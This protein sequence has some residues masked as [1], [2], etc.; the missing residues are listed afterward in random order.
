LGGRDLDTRR[1]GRE[2]GVRYLL[3]ADVAH[4]AE[5]IEVD[6]RLLDAEADAQVAARRFRLD[7]G[8]ADRS[9]DLLVAR[10]TEWS[11][12]A[13][14]IAEIE[15][16]KSMPGGN[17]R[18]LV[19]Q[20]DALLSKVGPS[21]QEHAQARRLYEQAAH[22]DPRLVD[23]WVGIFWTLNIEFEDN[24][25]ADRDALV[26]RMASVATAAVDADP[27]DA[28]AWGTRATVL[29]WQGRFAE[30]QAS[31]AEAQR[32]DPSSTASLSLEAFVAI[33]AGRPEDSLAAAQR[34]I[35]QHGTYRDW[36][37]RFVCWS[38]F[39]LERPIEAVQDCERA[40]ALS[41]GWWRDQEVL[42]AD[43]AQTGQLD[44]AAAV[45][46]ELLRRQPTLTIERLSAQRYSDHPRFLRWQ[47]QVFAGLRAA[48]VPER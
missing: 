31:I 11:H 22:L 1:V 40:S 30:A 17:A 26:A 20:A 37:V 15:R 45:K 6:A 43:Y 47:E 5:R 29:A 19:A 18:Y 21:L 28:A 7:S 3:R 4:V 34:A 42:L 24:L 33:V 10:I 14:R 23:A 16:A 48:G 8:P 44:K 2:L 25:A 38:T 13:V 46:A 32:L 27:A 9:R 41:N 39:A 36:T 35:A 12:V